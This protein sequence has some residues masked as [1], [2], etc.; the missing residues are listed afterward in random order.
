[1]LGNKEGVSWNASYLCP[2]LI[3]MIFDVGRGCAGG[4]KEE[5]SGKGICKVLGEFH[6]STFQQSEW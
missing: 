1:M 6:I 4:G 3:M 2:I 5:G